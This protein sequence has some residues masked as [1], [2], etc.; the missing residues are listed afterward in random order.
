MD[1]D[2]EDIDIFFKIYSDIDVHKSGRTPLVT[3]FF[4]L[5]HHFSFC[6]YFVLSLSYCFLLGNIQPVDIF[7]FMN[8]DFTTFEKC[9]FQIFDAD[10]SGKLNF[11]EFVCA[12]WNLLTI[13]EHQ[14][15][16]IV[17]LMKDPTGILRV[18]YATIKD[19]FDT[20][21]KR[22][23]ETSSIMQAIFHNLRDHYQPEL[24]LQDVCRW[25]SAVGNNS[26]LTPL[27]LL[28][29]KLRKFVIGEQYWLTRTT[30]RANDT[31]RSKVEYI[32]D[33]QQIIKVKL[34]EMKI[35]QNLSKQQQKMTDRNRMG[36]AQENIAR[37]QSILLDVFKLK[38]ATPNGSARPMS[39]TSNGS[40]RKTNK[41]AANDSDVPDESGFSNQEYGRLYGE[42]SKKK[43]KPTKS[44]SN[45]SVKSAG[46]ENTEGS[47]E[48]G[49]KSKK[50]KSSRKKSEKA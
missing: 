40:S 16:A 10:K 28:Q 25:S 4:L 34:G 20:V 37:K 7:T 35:K 43:L 13:P 32:K 17:Y 47:K 23:L 26:I 21:H 41:I 31:E 30:K 8:V 38:G 12:M 1:I 42:G 33:F 49:S 15:G 36:R 46:N 19:A 3:I 44:E 24:S 2:E 39:G 9:V 27:L 50:E 45:V 48:K 22:K 18:H 14:L 11:L 29:L 5:N 6:L